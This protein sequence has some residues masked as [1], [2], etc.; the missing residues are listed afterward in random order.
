MRTN[1]MART[2]KSYGPGIPTLMPSRADDRRG[3]G[4]QKARRTEE[5]TYKP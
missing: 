2:A 1:D 5:I 4:G 3:D